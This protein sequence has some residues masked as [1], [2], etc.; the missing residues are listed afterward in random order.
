MKIRFILITSPCFVASPRAAPRVYWCVG[1]VVVCCAGRT[2]AAPPLRRIFLHTELSESLSYEYYDIRNVKHARSGL[3]EVRT[4]KSRKQERKNKNEKR[5]KWNKTENQKKNIRRHKRQK[6]RGRRSISSALLF[7]RVGR[8]LP[9][10][11][12]A[13]TS[14]DAGK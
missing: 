2:A 8:P 4:P 9:M 7:S 14:L 5:N 1:G 10:R 3:S 6:L 12:S 11:S 13:R